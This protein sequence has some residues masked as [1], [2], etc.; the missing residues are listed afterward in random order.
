VLEDEGP[1]SHQRAEGAKEVG[2]LTDVDKGV[3]EQGGARH[4][5]FGAYG[6]GPEEGLEKG[7]GTV[8]VAAAWHAGLPRAAGTRKRRSGSMPL[9]AR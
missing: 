3:D 2:G 6:F 9:S 4:G 7:D 1:A 8:L 5:D